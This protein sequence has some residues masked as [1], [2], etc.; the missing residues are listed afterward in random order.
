MEL[1]ERKRK[2]LAAVVELYI[3]T[4]EPVGSKALCELPELSVS[5][6]T[7]RNEMSELAEMGLLEQPHTSAG[8]IPSQEGYRY[9][10]DHLMGRH[11]L[12]ADQRRRMDSL[13]TL[14]PGDPEKVLG[15]AGEVLADLT[16]CAAVSTTP[17]DAQASI[18]RVE[19]VPVSSSTAMIV[20]LTTSGILKSGLC[21]TMVP[22]DERFRTSFANIAEQ[23]FIGCPVSELTLPQIQTLAAS[24]GEHALTMSPALITLAQ[25]AREA[26]QA[27]ILLDG[28]T[29]LLSY[30]GRGAEVREALEFLRD[31]GPLGQLIGSGGDRMQVFIGSENV[32]RQLRHFSMILA[33]YKL[34]G[35]TGGTIGIIGPTRMDYASLIP[36]I[37]YLSA[38]VGKLLSE[39]LGGDDSAIL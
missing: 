36:H 16:N 24:L 29:N 38:I 6:A 7:I 31:T 22:I 23:H 27:E 13:F 37:E 17:A 33:P 11:E 30:D 10:I 14:N 3:K 21:R 28:Q 12:T 2:I 26:A 5:S 35:R 20:L 39:A 25:L 18:K 1:S 8:R 32:F 4:G 15:Q 19:L 34:A 9:Y